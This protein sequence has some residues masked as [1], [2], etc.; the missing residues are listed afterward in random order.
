MKNLIL[1]LFFINITIVTSQNKNMEIEYEYDQ[2]KLNNYGERE[3]E[4]IHTSYDQKIEYRHLYQKGKLIQAT[5]YRYWVEGIRPLIGKYQD[6]VPFE[7]YFVYISELEIP[8][9]DYY[10][11]GIFK[12]KYNCSLLD[13]ISNEGQ[14]FNLKFTKTTYQNDKPQNGL[15]HKEEYRVENAHLLASEYYK[16]GKITNADF[17]VMATHYAELFKLKFLPNGYTI[18]K[19]SLPNVEDEAIDNKYRSI[20]VAFDDSKNGNILFEVENKLIMK[21]EFSYGDISHKIKPLNRFIS[22]FF[23]NDNSILVAQSSNLETNNELY[24]EAYGYNPNLISRVF[25]MIT[26]QPIPYFSN[27]GNNDYSL[28]LDSD[29]EI[30]T[31]AILVLDE[32]G[33]PINGFLIEQQSYNVYKYTQYEDS[34]IIS[35]K[36]ALS[37][38]SLKEL[39]LKIQK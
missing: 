15:V 35:Q 38:E 7:G 6:E 19:E 4:L 36:E 23:L 28:L 26:S 12:A 29:K 22:Y 10:E 2:E 34:K 21:Y 33:N 5:N 11:N 24:N 39:I 16:D 17:W 8:Y 3:G 27:E 13:A 37:S 31:N 9:I 32:K 25:M 18:Y 20:T 1:I 30:N 14:E